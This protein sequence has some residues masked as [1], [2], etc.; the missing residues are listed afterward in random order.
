M[1]DIIRRVLKEDVNNT[2]YDKV[3]KVMRRPYIDFLR[4][5]GLGDKKSVEEIM[6]RKFGDGHMLYIPKE[7]ESVGVDYRF[8]WGHDDK[9]F[10]EEHKYT[11]ED[12]VQWDH[13]EKE[14]ELNQGWW[15]DD[16]SII[17]RKRINSDGDKE[18]FELTDDRS[19]IKHEYYTDT[20]VDGTEW[21]NAPIEVKN[22]K[23]FS[24]NY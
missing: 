11:T 18:Y 19:E 8:S 12:K 2:L 23:F 21:D 3:I 14:K 16:D 1:K 20:D 6:K 4:K 7:Y 24:N 10:Y 5:N 13:L 15:G 22:D 17:L 9:G